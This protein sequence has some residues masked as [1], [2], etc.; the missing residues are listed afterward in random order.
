MCDDAF[1]AVATREK[2]MMPGLT[3]RFLGISGAAA[4]A[5]APYAAAAHPQK[6]YPMCAFGT[7][8]LAP[9]PGEDERRPQDGQAACHAVR[10][11]ER[12]RIVHPSAKR[13]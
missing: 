5:L 12:L 4:L 8:I 7:V 11:A 1:V 6:L 2:G 3:V 9:F 13:R 10:L